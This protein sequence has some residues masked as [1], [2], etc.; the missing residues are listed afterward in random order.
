MR[1]LAADLRHALDPVAFAG[2]VLGFRP[3]PWQE[4]VLRSSSKRL[5]LNCSRQSGKSS[6]AAV[7]ALHKAVY[8]PGSLV[9]LVNPSLRQSGELFR[10]VTD[11]LDRLPEGQD[12]IEDNSLSFQLANGSRVL[13]LPASEATVRGFSNVALIVGRRAMVSAGAR[14]CA[15][16]APGR[17]TFC[18]CTMSG[19]ARCSYC[20]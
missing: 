6:V 9:L 7:V 10:K 3:D 12:R 16:T 18:R 14:S 19:S 17:A 5:L 11:P 1:N 15:T 8:H 2:D 13:S 20:S 4:R